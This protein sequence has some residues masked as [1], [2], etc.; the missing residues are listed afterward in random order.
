MSE[1]ESRVGAAERELV[2]QGEQ[3]GQVK[4]EMVGLRAD[5][6]SVKDN[7][8]RL[9]DRDAAKP[10]G[11]TVKTIAATCGGLGSVAI[12][13]WWLIGSSPAVRDLEKR[14]DH[15]DDP[16]IGRVPRLEKK[17][18]QIGTWQVRVTRNP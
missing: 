16:V 15:L 1:I 12:V 17:L 5:V 18:E 11:L 8:Q 7:V 10:Q 13:V 2:R 9:V 3:I 6:G 14:V 4:S